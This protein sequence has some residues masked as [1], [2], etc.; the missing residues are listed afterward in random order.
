MNGRRLF[1][2]TRA[3][4]PVL[5]GLIAMGW[6]VPSGATLSINNVIID[7]SDPGRRVSDV[8]L[9]N[10][11]KDRLYV[12]VEPSRIANP[13]EAVERRVQDPDPEKL[14]LL[15]TPARIVLE[16]G[17]RKLLRFAV[18][19]E[20]RNVDAIYR[21]TVKP[22]AGRVTSAVSGV[23]VMVGYDLLVIRRPVRPQ[24]AV[25]GARVGGF[26]VL[27]NTGNTNALLFDGKQCSPQCRPVETKRLYPGNE[28]RVKING[29][30]PVTYKMQVGKTIE[31]KNF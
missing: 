27:R 9:E 7:F 26:L 22:V 17:E 28:W 5:C 21:V 23:K 31:V 19:G 12:T 10:K 11:G 20:P 18:M 15:V 24:A 25:V 14:G 13:G 4:G 8:E 30:A 3:C 29:A 16:P 6:S 2:Y 1:H